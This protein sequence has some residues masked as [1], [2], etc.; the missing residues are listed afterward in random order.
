MTRAVAK[1][2]LASQPGKVPGSSAFPT[3]FGS[4][5]H[6]PR[7]HD[8]LAA[9]FDLPIASVE[10]VYC[11]WASDKEDLPSDVISSS[12]WREASYRS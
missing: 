5:R 12:E 6:H 8:L 1:R 2:S 4:F 10:S 9:A 3:S 11:E 7:F